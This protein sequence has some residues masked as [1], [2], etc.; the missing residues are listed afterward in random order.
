MDDMNGES[1]GGGGG[2]GRQRERTGVVSWI[3]DVFRK[4]KQ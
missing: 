4:S 3:V 1:G 2:R